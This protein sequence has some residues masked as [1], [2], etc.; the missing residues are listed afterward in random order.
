MHK[1]KGGEGGGWGLAGSSQGGCTQGWDRGNGFLPQGGKTADGEE[2]KGRGKHN[3]ARRCQGRT[4]T[5]RHPPARQKGGGGA[6]KAP[7]G[8]GRPAAGFPGGAA[9]DLDCG[10]QRLDIFIFKP[11]FA[12]RRRALGHL[13]IFSKGWREFGGGRGRVIPGAL[14]G[15]QAQA[16]RGLHSVG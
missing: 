16:T 6:K 15:G 4:K 2:G 13:R 10:Q 8:G 9:I 5:Q 3:K 12:G 1:E 11:F 14:F 7:S